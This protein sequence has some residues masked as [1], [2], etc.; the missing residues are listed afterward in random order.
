M[1][2][3]LIIMTVVFFIF[4]NIFT[5]GAEAQIIGT[6]NINRGIVSVFYG[7]AHHKEMRVLI[8]K[9]GQRFSYRLDGEKKERFP[10]QMGNGAYI[11][12]LM[13][14]TEGNKYR[15]ILK[16]EIKVNLA[17][18]KIIYLN[19]IQ[20]IKW[21]SSSKAVQKAS[22]LTE[23][24]T[25]DIDK[26][27]A[28]YEYIIHEIEYDYK[29]AAN[30]SSHYLPDIDHIFDTKLGICYDYASLFAAMLRSQGIPAQLVKGYAS[31]INEYHAW[32]EV[33]IEAL[34]G[35][36][37]I[38]TTQDAQLIK[39]NLRPDMIKSPSDFNRTSHI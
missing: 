29:K 21:D 30:T 23:N 39:S 36:V 13:E 26:V 18:D 22:E 31:N 20:E 25:A 9:D 28:I 12:R 24:L 2:K 38:D 8:E 37:I 17:D 5:Y 32:N 7:Q 1:K 35:W 3:T 16:Q 15:E 4:A 27:R 34:G 33:Y 10:L 6:E 14:N 19:S 11:V